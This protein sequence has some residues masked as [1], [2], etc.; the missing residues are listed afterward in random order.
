MRFLLVLL[1]CFS[2]ALAAPAGTAIRN[3]A[4]AIV[5]DQSYW[6]NVVE[7]LVQPQCVPLLS[8][9]GSPALPA[10]QVGALPGGFAYLSYQ[11]KNS[12]NATFDFDLGW[13]LGQSDLAP[14]A[15]AIYHD[16]NRNAQ[17]DP[18]EVP[19]N[20]VSLSEEE[21]IYLVLEVRLN[22]TGTGNLFLTP[23]ATCADGTSDEDNY[24]QVR[25]GNGPQ[26][27]VEKTVDAAA[28]EPGAEVRFTLK[29]KNIGDSEAS[30]PI[31]LRD[32]LGQGELAGLSLVEGS[33]Q[34]GGGLLEY[35]SNGSTWS[36]TPVAG[37]SE[38]RLRLE[39][40]AA[41]KAGQ[42]S[43]RMRSDVNA[44]PGLR[45]NL[46]LVQ[47]GE[48]ELQSEVRF[49]V[50]PRFE[51]HLGPEANPRALPGGE[52]G[53]ADQQEG[54]L[55][56]SGRLCF[57]H[58]LLNAGT[59]A[60]G[61]KL[62]LVGLPSGMSASLEKLDG[63]ALVQPVALA[64]GE[65]LNFRLCLQSPMPLNGFDLTLSA[66]SQN[67]GQVNR[68]VDK[69]L[70][71][72]DPVGIRLLKSVKPL[73]QIEPGGALEYTL[74][75]ENTLPIALTQVVIEDALQDGLFF[76]QASDSGAYDATSRT[77]RW[78]LGRLESGQTRRLLLK[79]RVDPAL[80][81]NTRVENRF[82]LQVAELL[83]AKESNTV[84]NHVALVSLLLSKELSPGKAQVGDLLTYTV[85]LSNPNMAALSVRLEDTPASGLGYVQGSAEVGVQRREPL[86]QGGKLVWDGMAL[87][88]GQSLTI[89]YQMRVLA[90][91]KGTL[92][93][94]ALAEGTTS[95]GSKV[96][97][98][99]AQ[100]SAVIEPGVFSPANFLMGRVY[101]DANR[102]G[103]FD[104]GDLPLPGARLV[105]DSGVQVITDAQG[106]YAFRDLREG[107]W[108]V[109]LDPVS[110]PFART[111]HPDAVGDG[112]R[113]RVRVLGLTVSD[114][115]LEMP[116]G[117]AKVERETV[118]EFGPLRISKKLV[119][120]ARGTLVV[121]EVSSAEPLT[122]LTITD[123]LP[124]GASKVFDFEQFQGTQTLVYDAPGG[125]LTDPQARWKYP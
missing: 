46:A 2:L 92:V 90:G 89:T 76:I 13:K 29:V 106:R 112:Y 105:L 100:A 30:G 19:I 21:E 62:E 108:T 91:A 5:G 18:G 58:S 59:T 28:I 15:V 10:M 122:N 3:Q 45:S 94:M 38:L 39:G 48:V 67:G 64:M 93:N 99:R 22:P 120:L 119:T 123:P 116:Q 86:Q 32:P 97:S 63:S 104:P 11:L 53:A 115:T 107:L 34:G 109:M 96:Q 98:S 125:V 8:P 1:T 74:Q 72:L 82:R 56:S 36:T 37:L 71:V 4:E 50:L 70:G 42:F 57:V 111:P 6:S 65:M 83:Q 51:P 23:T 17:R 75:V 20:R 77:V 61:Y 88:G 24:S 73:D 49:E 9:Q 102:N 85:K 101:L 12:G 40:L 124:G 26:L 78:S 87:A 118:L 35:S 31:Y 60:D 47:W 95:S 121:L 52:G 84:V 110:A 44:A 54:Y 7:T 66:V 103:L 43:F 41:G 25:V 69:V 80:P 33:V 114:F 14:L 16:V 117:S 81:F 79:T 68:T 113:H 55:V 27:M